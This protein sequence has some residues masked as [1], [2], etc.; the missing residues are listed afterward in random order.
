MNMKTFKYLL[1]LLLL[2]TLLTGCNL[3]FGHAPTPV[4]PTQELNLL[5]TLTQQAIEHSLQETI[6]APTATL[7]PTLTLTPLPPETLSPASTSLPSGPSEVKFRGGGTIAYY[8]R[9]IKAGEQ[10][11]YA[12]EAGAG[13][14]LIVVASSEDNQV[15]FEVS[16]LED[17]TVLVP[18]S[19]NASSV[20]LPLPQTGVYQVTLTSPEDNRYFLSF[21]VPAVLPV[22]PGANPLW[23]EGYIDVL[24]AFHPAAF[25]RVR[26]LMQLQ[27]GSVLNVSL[28]SPALDGLTLAL[29]GADDGQPYLRHEVKSTGVE[30]F[31]VPVSQAYYLDVYSISGESASFTLT[32]A[33][34]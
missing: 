8:Q 31:A 24:D 16:W 5:A 6:N 3:P 7:P 13:Q 19:D 22:S 15:Y 28:D 33:V 18:F 11:S 12:I 10:Q 14:N 2:T 32:I 29:L 26:Y 23:V 20:R 27:A 30:N 9:D 17:G 1:P 21:E 34:E 4:P 25:T